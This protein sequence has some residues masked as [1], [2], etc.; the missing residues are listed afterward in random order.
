MADQTEVVHPS[1]QTPLSP[2]DNHPAQQEASKR[3]KISMSEIGSEVIIYNEPQEIP[4]ESNFHIVLY[5]FAIVAS[6]LVC[7]M[8]FASVLIYIS[9]CETKSFEALA[10]VLV[11]FHVWKICLNIFFIF[12]YS[13][14][15]P[16]FRKTYIFDI[17]LSVGYL[18]V[19]VVLF[20]YLQGK[21]DAATLPFF[22]I[23]HIVLT[24]VR[25]CV[26]EALATPFLPFSLLAFLESLAILYVALKLS[27][28]TAHSDWTWVLLYFY[29]LAILLLLVAYV[30]IAAV[31]V[32]AGILVFKPDILRGID[33]LVIL[34]IFGFLFYIIWNGFVFYYLLSGIHMILLENQIGPGITATELPTRVTVIAYV[35]LICATITLIILVLFLVYLKET[36]SRMFN[37]GKATEI[38]LQSFAKGLN[39]GVIQQSGSYFKK[40]EEKDVEQTEVEDIP[41]VGACIICCDK[42]S[43]VMIHPCGHSGICKDC[44]TECLKRSDK[45]PHCKQKMDKIYLIYFDQDKKTY[46]AKGALKFKNIG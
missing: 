19:F 20:L 8:A 17:V 11:V 9:Q 45:C 30:F 4:N 38:S 25:F 46:M 28:P 21:V 10:L 32:L 37:Q 1:V 13:G 24:L 26:G 18:S 42:P 29:L 2:E 16:A 44:M 3:D 6:E 39:L 43:E 31:L 27:N 14:R 35:M 23:P 33:R 15:N 5:I 12:A 34:F 36:L 22:V 41:E 40:K 7:K